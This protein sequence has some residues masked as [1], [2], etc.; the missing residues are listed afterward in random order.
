MGMT[1]E[2]RKQYNHQYY[3]QNIEK[4]KQRNKEYA[5]K[6]RKVLT[7]EEK[8]ELYKKWRERHLYN[9]RKAYWAKKGFPE[10]PEKK[11]KVKIV[12]VPR[13][14]KQRQPIEKYIRPPAQPYIPAYQIVIDVS[15]NYAP[16]RITW[17]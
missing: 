12:R 11:K 1:K 17:D 14:R 9:R 8:K 13:E 15:E 3:L 5:A 6:H 4:L 7:E 10:P 16:Y 2:E